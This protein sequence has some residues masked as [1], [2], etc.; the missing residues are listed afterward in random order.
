MSRWRRLPRPPDVHNRLRLLSPTEVS[1]SVS[2]NIPDLVQP[3]PTLLNIS[4]SGMTCNLG[5]PNGV[6]PPSKNQMLNIGDL[7][8]ILDQ[9][10]RLGQA[11]DYQK[12]I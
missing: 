11:A 1:I 7:I 6:Q 4:L 3:N 2:L 5:H 12:T 10:Y 9:R 8:S